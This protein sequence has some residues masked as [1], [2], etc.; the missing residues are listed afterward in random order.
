SFASGLQILVISS[1]SSLWLLKTSPF[2]VSEFAGT[3]SS[4]SPT[5]GDHELAQAIVSGAGVT[6]PHGLLTDCYDE[7]GSRYQL[8]LYVLAAPVNLISSPAAAGAAALDGS[9]R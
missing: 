2:A 8:P 3:L 1:R 7:L 6:L 4:R 9:A 5:S